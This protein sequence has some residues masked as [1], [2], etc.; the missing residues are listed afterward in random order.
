MSLL[1][2]AEARPFAPAIRVS[3]AIGNMPPFYAAG[4]VGYFKDDIRLTEQEKQLILE[5]ADSGASECDLADLPEPIV[6]DDSAWPLGDPDLVVNLPPHSPPPVNKDQYI[7]LVSDHVFAE[8]TWA[9]ALH[10]KTLSK[11]VVHH[12]TQFLWSPEL[13]IPPN[14]KTFSHLT[15]EFPLFTWVPGLRVDPLPDGQAIRLPKSWRVASRTHFKP[16]RERVVEKMEL[17]IYF[18][19]GTI[20]TVQKVIGVQFTKLRIPPGE[21]DYTLSKKT[22]FVEAA[23]VSHFRVHMHLRGK[24]S[25]IIFHYPDGTSETVFDLP[26]YRFSWQRYYYLAEPK[27]VPRGTVAEFIA[28]WDNSANN[29]SNPDPTVWCSWGPRT[30]DEMFDA[31]VFYTPEMKLASPLEIRDGRRI[32]KPPGSK[33]APGST[34][35]M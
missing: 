33:K 4:P 22:R 2:Y 3:V 19:D 27:L 14:G 25:K 20:E 5:W 1:T 16:T 7:T 35:L 29:P 23:H 17:G 9:R 34:I 13:E 32:D 12:S 15:T 26:R 18:A 30:V 21:S 8:E 6:W 24:S 28:V 31:N 11:S 10:L